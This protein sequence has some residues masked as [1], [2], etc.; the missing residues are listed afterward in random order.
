MKL[1]LPLVS[2]C[3]HVVSQVNEEFKYCVV[4]CENLAQS[5]ET[6]GQP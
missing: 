6:L 1:G 4:C 5:S 2:S 3:L